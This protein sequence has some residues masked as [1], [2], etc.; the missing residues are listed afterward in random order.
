MFVK[1]KL[2]SEIYKFSSLKNYQLFIK[3]L[4]IGIKLFKKLN[5][6]F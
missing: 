5:R 1:F 2:L 4:S 3:Q 6:L